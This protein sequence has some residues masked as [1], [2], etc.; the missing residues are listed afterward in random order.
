MKRWKPPRRELYS[1]CRLPLSFSIFETEYE[2]WRCSCT[3]FGVERMQEGAIYSRKMG[4]L[5][6]GS[7]RVLVLFESVDSSEQ[8]LLGIC[9]GMIKFDSIAFRIRD[10]I[11]FS[12]AIFIAIWIFFDRVLRVVLIFP[13]GVDGFSEIVCNFQ[14]DL[15]QTMDVNMDVYSLMELHVLFDLLSDN[16]YEENRTMRTFV[17][18]TD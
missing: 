3:R 7:S 13:E 15:F 18:E 14:G 12:G 9:R 5:Q 6:S 1:S 10:A 16:K 17:L 11:T 4:F 2:S 8:L